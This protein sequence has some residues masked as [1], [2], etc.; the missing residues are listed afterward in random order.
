MFK[1]LTDES[2]EKREKVREQTM[3]SACK[4]KKTDQDILKGNTLSEETDGKKEM[5]CYY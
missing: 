3:R 5:L 2:R 1:R 4:K